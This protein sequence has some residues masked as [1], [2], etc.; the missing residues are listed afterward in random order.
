VM[1][2]TTRQPS[3]CLLLVAALAVS[4]DDVLTPG[5]GRSNGD[6]FASVGRLKRP[7]QGTRKNPPPLIPLIG[8]EGLAVVAKRHADERER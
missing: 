3:R 4:S 5:Q 6:A 1:T 8:G 7:P 2:T